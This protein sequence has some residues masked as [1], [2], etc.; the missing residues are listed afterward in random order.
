MNLKIGLASDHAGYSL[1]VKVIEYLKNKNYL[2]EDFGT[3]SEESCD[4][5]DFAHKLANAVE[6]N[7]VNFGLS[8]CGSGNGI[9]IA[10]NK[11]MKVRSALCWNIE[12]SKLARLHNDANICAIPA[13]FTT[14][15]EAIEI[16]DAF[17]STVFEGGRHQNRIEKITKF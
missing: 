9:N 1:K 11:H 15:N 6:N 8:F 13:R 4:Y 16:I 17:L 7:K 12:I 3:Y 14:Y 2:V 5:P 10:A